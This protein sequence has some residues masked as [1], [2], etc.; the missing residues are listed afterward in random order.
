MGQTWAARVPTPNTPPILPRQTIRAR[1]ALFS[2]IL[3]TVFAAGG[4]AGY[5]VFR[6]FG[7]NKE[8]GDRHAKMMGEADLDLAKF[9]RDQIGPGRE[10]GGQEKAEPPKPLPQVLQEE[11]L[12]KPPS[13]KEPTSPPEK[14]DRLPAPPEDE[15]PPPQ[16]EEPKP[17][18]PPPPPRKEEA[19]LKDSTALSPT[20]P[21]TLDPS[22][23]EVTSEVVVMKRR[24]ETSDE[25]LRKQL[26][27]VPELGLGQTAAAAVYAPLLELQKVGQFPSSLEPDYGRRFLV[28]QAR[29][30]KR[31]DLT[32]LPWR[33]G[34]D[35]QL[36]KESAD[37]LHVLSLNLRASL[38]ASTPQGDIRPDPDR[39]R[40]LLLGGEAAR[41]AA[42][43]GVRGVALSGVN[44]AEIKPSEWRQPGAIPAL[45]QLL[46]HENT[47]IRLLLVELLSQIE[48]KEASVA[49]AHRALFDLSS[50]V[51][52][53]A[54]Q[55][56]VDRPMVEYREALLSGFRHPWPAV[57]DHAAEALVAI[58]DRDALPALVKLLTEPD[59]KLPVAIKEKDKEV[60]ATRELVRINHLS[61]CMICHAP[62]LSKEDL[63]RGRVPVPGE[64]PPP[65]YYAETSGMFVR[66][67]T[68]FLRQDFSIV[69]PVASSGKWPG[70]QRFDYLVRT[71]PLSRAERTRFEQWQKGNPKSES[72]EQREALLFTLKELTGKNLGTSYEDW[73]PLPKLAATKE[74]TKEQQPRKDD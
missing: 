43:S 4:L 30:L 45:M 13:P 25:D 71:R 34:A 68:T 7:T 54:V 26:L 8:A 38:R 6:Y 59:P 62:S 17:K 28:E 72:Y 3:L 23:K 65:L 22:P 33:Q 32:Y 24:K 60:L 40:A 69:Q 73:K 20:R 52:E 21:P 12:T 15:L 35:S 5:G 41:S 18:D 64:D 49:L 58:K 37:R 70:N 63:V 47:P 61:N 16:K 10:P 11:S 44:D 42:R 50:Q 51:R 74:G 53:R 56:L 14:V 9:T 2:A 48:G 67:D 31:P 39:L 29:L 19:K 27:S 46:Q 36:G 66:A 57:A 1:M 55:A